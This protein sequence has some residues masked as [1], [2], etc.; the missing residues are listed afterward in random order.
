MRLRI[1]GIQL[2]HFG[3]CLRCAVKIASVLQQ[4]TQVLLRILG[5]RVQR[6]RPLVSM[7]GC[8]AFTLGFLGVAKVVES[9]RI[10]R[11]QLRGSCQFLDRR[12][13]VAHAQQ[14]DTEVKVCRL[15]FRID[16]QCSLKL[17]LCIGYLVVLRQ[18]RTKFV[19]QLGTLR[20]QCDRRFHLRDGLWRFLLQTQGSRQGAMGFCVFG[21]QLYCLVKLCDRLVE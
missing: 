9:Q 20:R 19:M 18:Q 15:V 6:N 2:N 4:K 8:F 1:I 12:I 16:L 17:L 3:V 7:N 14:H 10:L 5:V 13:P 21:S 11:I